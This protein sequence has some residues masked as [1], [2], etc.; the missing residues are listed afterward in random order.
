MSCVDGKS[1]SPWSHTRNRM[2]TPKIKVARR[3]LQCR[4]HQRRRNRDND[5]AVNDSGATQLRLRLVVGAMRPPFSVGP[6]DLVKAITSGP[7]PPPQQGAQGAW[8]SAPSWRQVI[9]SVFRSEHYTAA[10]LPRRHRICKPRTAVPGGSLSPQ[11]GASLD[12]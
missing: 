4:L 12:L 3:Y 8:E 7:S 10:M 1:P 2:Q 9:S 11:H 6:N 5:Q